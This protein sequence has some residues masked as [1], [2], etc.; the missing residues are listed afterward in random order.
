MS[1]AG[2]KGLAEITCNRGG[3]N[4]RAAPRNRY[5]PGL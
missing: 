1:G 3:L 4:R 2:S 5:R